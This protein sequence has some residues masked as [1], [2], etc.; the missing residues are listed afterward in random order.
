MRYFP[1]FIDLKDRPVFVFGGG[2]PAL[3]KTRLLLKAG[4][5][6]TVFADDAEA[7]IK[8]LAALG[9]IEIAPVCDP[10]AVDLSGLA[11]IVSSAGD[12]TDS[13]ISRRA[14]ALSIP[15]NVVDRTE[16]CSFITPAIIDRGTVLAAIGTEGAA[17]VLARRLRAKIEALLPAR[18]GDLADLIGSRRAKL[19]E[20]A[21]DVSARRAFWEKIVDGPIGAAALDGRLEDAATA[22]DAEIS[23]R[24]KDEQRQGVVYLVGAGPGDPE[25]LTLKALRV[26]QDADIIFHDDLVT[27]DILDLARRDAERVFVGKRA[28]QK[29]VAQ[30]DINTELAASAR[31][32]LRVVRLK[33]GDPFVFG[34][35]GEELEHLEEQGIDVVVVPGITA[36]LGCA[37]EAGLP[38]TYRKE[39]ARLTL[40]TAHRAADAEAIDWSGLV[41]RDTTLAV[42]MGRATCS[43]V[44]D[45]L[46]SAGR[47]PETPVVVIARGTRPDAH[48]VA[49]TLK[50]LPSLVK[51]VGEGPALLVLGQVVRRSRPWRARLGAAISALSKRST[52]APEKIEGV[53]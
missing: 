13:V 35:G 41:R 21:H 51:E 34:R 27:P 50:E 29:C 6:V 30:R 22:L 17:P 2:E 28:G 19:A 15:V 1:I 40:L 36:A 5:R 26:L 11:A 37:A 49:G 24:L 43:V 38:L 16:L 4:A 12:P 10:E 20:S 44:A 3:N 18:L 32:G 46:I 33:G 25:L 9:K 14:R 42:Y 8:S 7:E 23:G 52:P 48:S 31:R 39:S 45:G 53:E 47:D